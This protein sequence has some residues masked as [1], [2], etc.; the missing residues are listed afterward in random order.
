[1]RR[2]QASLAGG[3]ASLMLVDV[4]AIPVRE[5]WGTEDTWIPAD[6]WLGTPARR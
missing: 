2:G 6:R 4:V 1:M 3:Y 5:V